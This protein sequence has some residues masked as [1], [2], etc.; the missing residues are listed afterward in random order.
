MAKSIA[1]AL[2]TRDLRV[3]DNPVLTATA[4]ADAVIPLFVLDSA[5]AAYAVP[6]RGPFPG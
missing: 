5:I 6:N 3:H 2:F 1:V 4:E